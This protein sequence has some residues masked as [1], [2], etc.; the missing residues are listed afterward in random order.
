MEVCS[1]CALKYNDN[2]FLVV[3]DAT[4]FVV[5]EMGDVGILPGLKLLEGFVLRI[6]MRAW[7]VSSSPLRTS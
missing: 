2:Y 5:T 6:L 1:I 3:D 7:S 4:V